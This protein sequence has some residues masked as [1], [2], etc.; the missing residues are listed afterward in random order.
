MS[1]HVSYKSTHQKT[2][3]KGEKKITKRENQLILQLLGFNHDPILMVKLTYQSH[4]CW[5]DDD[6]CSTY[7]M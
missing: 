6:Y 3:P 1:I 7:C 5:Q 2:S 4:S